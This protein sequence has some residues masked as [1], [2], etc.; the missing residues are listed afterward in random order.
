MLS[1]SRRATVGE[2]CAGAG[3]TDACSGGSIELR[4]EPLDLVQ[5][6]RGDLCL[7]RPLDIPCAAARG[8]DRDFVVVRVKANAR[9][10]DVID[11]DR[12][13]AL[14]GQLAESVIDCTGTV[15]GS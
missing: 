12:V 1:A 5:D 2:P 13:E 10:G 15:L 14:S 7:A 8:Q 3:G 9:L 4:A 6:R 11:D